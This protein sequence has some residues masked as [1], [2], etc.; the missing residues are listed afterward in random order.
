MKPIKE[1]IR[2]KMRTDIA[3]DAKDNI[4]HLLS[5]C[6]YSPVQEKI[7]QDIRFRILYNLKI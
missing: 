6:L 2:P 5:D 1:L 7:D 3:K 4:W